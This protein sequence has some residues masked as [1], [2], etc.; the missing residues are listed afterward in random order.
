MANYWVM[1]TFKDWAD[2]FIHNSEIGMDEEGVNQ[3]YNQY[4]HNQLPL[5]NE[6]ILRRFNQFCK[7]VQQ[8]DYVI[9]GV[10]QTTAFKMKLIARITGDY[11]FD[12][13]HRPYRHIRK[14]EIMKVFDEP[15]NVEKWSQTQRIELIDDND[16]ID[17]F[18]RV[19]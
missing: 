12:P 1:K 19:L 15:I 17:T 10:G 7:W 2:S 6:R 9:V 11:Y 5:N 16:F 14:V 4:P 3:N 18:V 13:N 8:G